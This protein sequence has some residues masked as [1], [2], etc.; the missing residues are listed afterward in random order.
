MVSLE[1]L[2]PASDQADTAI[3]DIL[4]APNLVKYLLQ[5]SKRGVFIHIKSTGNMM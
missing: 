1:F 3:V 4:T 5:Q 2:A